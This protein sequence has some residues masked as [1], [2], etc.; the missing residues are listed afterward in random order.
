LIL[1]GDDGFKSTNA[2][3]PTAAFNWPPLNLLANERPVEDGIW[4]W[5]A[6]NITVVGQGQ[7]EF[8]V[9]TYA[10][11]RISITLDKSMHL[12]GIA[13]G[14][15]PQSYNPATGHGE[16]KVEMDFHNWAWG[17]RETRLPLSAFSFG[18]AGSA[19]M[20]ADIVMLQFRDACIND[21][22]RG[23]SHSWE[24]SVAEN[25][26][27]DG[28]EGVSSRTSSFSFGK[29]CEEPERESTL[30]DPNNW[31]PGGGNKPVPDELPGIDDR[32][33]PYN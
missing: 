28:A 7:D 23:G 20:S 13:F 21:E 26:P 22:I 10:F 8:P 17:M 3:V 4:S 32:H 6:N 27:A 25:S 18:E 33:Q 2:N 14:L 12:L 24:T 15:L 5:R 9:A 16:L 1:A 29:A 19:Q 11:R 31:P 30:K